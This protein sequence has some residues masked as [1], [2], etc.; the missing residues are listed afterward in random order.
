MYILL[1]PQQGRNLLALLIPFVCVFF[2]GCDDNDYVSA[3]LLGPVTFFKRNVNF[4]TPRPP[5]AIKVAF[6]GRLL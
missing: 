6:E 3:I 5:R 2:K 4:V 1:A